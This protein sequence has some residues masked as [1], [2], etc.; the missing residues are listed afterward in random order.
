MGCLKVYN[1][2]SLF[3][4]RNVG[5]GAVCLLAGKHSPSCSEFG[6]V[7]KAGE[8]LLKLFLLMLSWLKLHAFP[9]KEYSA[10]WAKP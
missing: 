8:G 2:K 7:H 3:I 1:L 4:A 6:P 9:G 5:E 10:R